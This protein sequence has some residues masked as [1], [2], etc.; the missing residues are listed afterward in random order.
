MYQGHG[1]TV[2]Q[3]YAVTDDSANIKEVATALA[4]DRFIAFS[5]WRWADLQSKTGEHPVYRYFYERPRPA[6]V[7]GGPVSYGA[8]HSSEIEYAMG[9][10]GGNKVFAWTQ[11]DYA[12]SKI[13]QGYFVNFIKKG[14]PN[15]PGLP[16]WHANK[17]GKEVWVQHINVNTRAEP[18]QHR[19]RY[20]FME[21]RAAE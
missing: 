12:V 7:A 4:S 3:L 8:V 21:K 13:M 16:E 2:L 11:D 20:E 5:T 17:K 19:D 10:L 18:E 15:G 6:T 14:D 1:D 9:N